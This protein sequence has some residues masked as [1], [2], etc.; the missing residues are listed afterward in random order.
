[1][2]FLD[3]SD[4]G[5]AESHMSSV[6]GASDRRSMGD[7][8]RKHVLFADWRYALG[9]R[10]SAARRSPLDLDA[11]VDHYH[12]PIL[13]MVVGILILSCLDATFTLILMQAGIVEEWNPLMR[14]LIEHDVQLFANVKMA[15]TAMALV[16]LVTCYHSRVLQRRIPVAWFLVGTLVG[17]T[18]LVGYE[19]ILL[20][21]I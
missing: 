1:V 12:P 15:V 10:R 7:R 5:F 19:V 17:Y 16:F 4:A 9:G 18:G 8:R 6:G 21:M 14:A 13:W 20:G 2:A 11:G 3:T